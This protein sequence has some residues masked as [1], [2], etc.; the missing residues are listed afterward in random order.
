MSENKEFILSGDL[1]CDY[2][3]RSDHTTIKDCLKLNG[4]KQLIDEPTRITMNTSSLIDI[5]ATTHENNIA[6]KFVYSSGASDHHLIGIVRKLNTKHFQPR[7]TLVRNYKGYSKDDFNS[8][9]H[10]Q[11]WQSVLN[12]GSF[13]EAWNGTI[14]QSCIHKHAPLIEKT[15]GGLALSLC[16]CYLEASER[17]PQQAPPTLCTISI[18]CH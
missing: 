11:N 17:L 6:L 15:I 8:D 16:L 13:N 3:K 4:F 1:N 7:R 18:V 5:I 12:L 14:L 10:L 2:L 9:L